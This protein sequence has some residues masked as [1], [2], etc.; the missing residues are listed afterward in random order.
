MS[1]STLTTWKLDL[2]HS[3]LLFKVRHLVITTVTGQ[4]N[5]FEA[6]FESANDDFTDAKIDFKAEVASISTGDANR[7]GHLKSPDFFDAASHPDLTFTSNALSKNAD[8]TYSLTGDLSLHGV[9]LPV[10]LDVELGGTVVDPYGQ[11]KVGFELNGKISRKAFGLTW[12]AFTEA[13]GAVV[14]DEV[15]IVASVQF[16]KQA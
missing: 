8:G 4:F 14:S 12:D 9:T 2:S 1:T 15:K 16:V 7:D 10:T 5:N 6:T 3:E 13:G 11:H